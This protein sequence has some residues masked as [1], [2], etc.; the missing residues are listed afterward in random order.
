MVALVATIHDFFGGT[1]ADDR[2]NKTWVAGTR[3]T[4]TTVF[5]VGNAAQTD[6]HR[7]R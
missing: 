5:G 1:E 3:P 4:M 2:G 6:N 7:M